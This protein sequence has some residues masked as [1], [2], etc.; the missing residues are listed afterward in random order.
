MLV[1]TVIP[2]REHSDF[3][4]RPGVLVTNRDGPG[5]NIRNK[6]FFW[7]HRFMIAKLCEV[8]KSTHCRA[9]RVPTQ[10]T[11]AKRRI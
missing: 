7:R 3:K 11:A 8:L 9:L 10:R 1:D 6:A 4:Y 5:T 2:A